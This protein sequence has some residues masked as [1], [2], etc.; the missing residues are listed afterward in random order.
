[1]ITEDLIDSIVAQLRGHGVTNYVLI[2][3]CPDTND[4]FEMSGGDHSW[5]VGAMHMFQAQLVMDEM[6]CR[7]G[8][9]SRNTH[10]QNELEDSE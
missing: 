3:R 6:D 5:K 4:S 9:S 7:R 8:G 2:A 1:M 10:G